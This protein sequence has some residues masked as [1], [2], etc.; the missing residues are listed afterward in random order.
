MCAQ[1]MSSP[2][3][4]GVPRTDTFMT[5]KSARTN[6]HAHRGRVRTKLESSPWLP[7]TPCA[8]RPRSA[9]CPCGRCLRPAT[10]SPCGCEQQSRP[11]QL[12]QDISRKPGT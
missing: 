12:V 5:N 10:T 1:G 8:L 7:A 11:S 9:S 3:L 2:L 4:L 6:R